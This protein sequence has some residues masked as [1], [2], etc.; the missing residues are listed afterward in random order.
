MQPFHAEHAAILVDA[1]LRAPSSCLLA[2]GASEI[3]VT[4]MLRDPEDENDF[5]LDLRVDLA[6]SR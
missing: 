3:R 4:Q 1:T 5:H 6:A 2:W